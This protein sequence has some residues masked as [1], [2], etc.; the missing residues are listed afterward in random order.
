MFRL[1]LQAYIWMYVYMQYICARAYMLH[2]EPAAGIYPPFSVWARRCQKILDFFSRIFTWKNSRKIKQEYAKN[3]NLNT[4]S[5]WYS[6]LK[7]MQFAYVKYGGGLTLENAGIYPRRVQNVT[8]T[9]LW[10]LEGKVYTTPCDNT[11][12]ELSFSKLSCLSRC[13][14]SVIG[15]PTWSPSRHFKEGR[16]A[17]SCNHPTL[18]D[19]HLQVNPSIWTVRN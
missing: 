1:L 8:Y 9:P 18:F 7:Y 14:V 13:V 5:S 2:S 16:R 3:L 11:S 12:I 19:T 10:P 17:T 4:W 15:D 6:T